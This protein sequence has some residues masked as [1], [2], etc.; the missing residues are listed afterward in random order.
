LTGA[1]GGDVV[2]GVGGHLARVEDDVA[3]EGAVEE[4]LDAEVKVARRAGDRGAQVGISVADV[5][6]RR[7]VA[8]DLD[9]RRCAWRRRGGAI[10]RHRSWK[11]RRAVGA[12]LRGGRRLDRAA[13]FSIAG[14]DHAFCS[15]A[16]ASRSSRSATVPAALAA[17]S[18]QN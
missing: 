10:L 9:D 11:G 16:R 1:V 13:G 5:D 18:D 14:E 4:G 2:D 6:D 3:D 15:R 8:S 12:W 17:R 7:V